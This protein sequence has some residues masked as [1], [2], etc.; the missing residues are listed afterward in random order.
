[1]SIFDNARPEEFLALLIKL[2]I[3]IEGADTTLPSGQINHLRTIIRV[4]SP[5]EFEE[6]ALQVNTTNNHF[7]HI[8]E[9]LLE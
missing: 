8:T 3:S 1:M 5:R 4:S 2:N 7:K 9:G 6:L